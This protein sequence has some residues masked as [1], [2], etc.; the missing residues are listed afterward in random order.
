M[1][2]QHCPKKETQSQISPPSHLCQLLS[3]FTSHSLPRTTFPSS[4]TPFL[5]N[6]CAAACMHATSHTIT[7]TPTSAVG[8][9]PREHLA[10]VQTVPGWLLSLCLVQHPPPSPSRPAPT[11]HSARITPSNTRRHWERTEYPHYAPSLR[12]QKKE[13]RTTKKK[14]KNKQGGWLTGLTKGE[15]RLNMGEGFMKRLFFPTWMRY[16]RNFFACLCFLGYLKSTAPSIQC[17][18]TEAEYVGH[19]LLLLGCRL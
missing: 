12:Q 11:P 10:E 4:L 13:Q 1:P 8:V 3:I 5:L 2:T 7:C 14:K 15:N 9:S 19:L 16:G 6:M 17:S 18:R